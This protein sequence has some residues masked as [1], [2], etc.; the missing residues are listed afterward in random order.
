[1]RGRASSAAC[2]LCCRLCSGEEKRSQFSPRTHVGDSEEEGSGLSVRPVAFVQQPADLSHS[3][4]HVVGAGLS[5]P[6]N[7]PLGFVI[8]AL[9]PNSL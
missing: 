1:M 2:R 9:A 6:F 5:Y 3:T 8:E 7:L 4:Q